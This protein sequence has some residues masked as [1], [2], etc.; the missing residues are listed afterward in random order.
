MNYTIVSQHTNGR[1][2]T[3]YTLEKE[4]YFPGCINYCICTD[5]DRGERL[6][7]LQQI[8][9]YFPHKSTHFLIKPGVTYQYDCLDLINKAISEYIAIFPLD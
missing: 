8:T 7:D 3:G 1:Q 5:N 6:G 9:V 2:V 4:D